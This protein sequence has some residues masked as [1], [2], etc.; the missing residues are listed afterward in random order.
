MVLWQYTITKLVIWN[1]SAY[2][3]D[4][5]RTLLNPFY[6][7]GPAD[8]QVLFPHSYECVKNSL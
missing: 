3:T 8:E 5:L 7:L 2:E 4:Y 6:T 1:A